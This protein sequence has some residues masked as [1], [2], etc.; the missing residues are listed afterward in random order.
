MAEHH[1]ENEAEQDC[2]QRSVVGGAA[3]AEPAGKQDRG[4]ADGE[5]NVSG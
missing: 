5:P 3:C 1:R 4:A 2:M